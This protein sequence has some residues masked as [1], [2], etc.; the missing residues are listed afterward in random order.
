VT[1][2]GTASMVPMEP[3]IVR[4]TT[5][6]EV[7]EVL[8]TATA[9]VRVMGNGRW[10]MGGGPFAEAAPLSVRAVAGVSAFSPGDLVLTAGAGTTLRELA[11]VAAAATRSA[12]W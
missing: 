3:P 6:A 10:L 2:L 4:P 7:A 8:R 1:E 9:P 11:T 5:T 12:A